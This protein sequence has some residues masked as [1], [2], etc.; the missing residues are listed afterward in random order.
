MFIGNL[1]NHWGNKVFC[2]CRKKQARCLGMT[3]PQKPLKPNENHGCERVRVAHVEKNHGND[4]FPE[5]LKNHWKNN[6][7]NE[8]IRFYYIFD[9]N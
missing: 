8:N 9:W 6:K 4:G 7:N 1:Q 3:V 5:N 2:S